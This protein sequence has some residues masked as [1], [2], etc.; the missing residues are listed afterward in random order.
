MVPGGG[1][2]LGCH[3][4]TGEPRVRVA[5]SEGFVNVRVLSVEGVGK[6]KGCCGGG[7]GHG[8]VWWW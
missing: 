6:E 8:D 3:G 4:G 5:A 1:S 2:G 7:D